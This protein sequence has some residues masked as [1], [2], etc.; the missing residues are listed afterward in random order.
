[1]ASFRLGSHGEEVRRIQERLAALG[2]YL[3][4]IDGA[5]GGGTEQAVRR[6]QQAERLGVDGVVGEETWEALFDETAPPPA[7]ASQ[8]VAYRCLALTG[9]FE[10]GAGFPDCFAGVSGDFDGQGLSMG[11]CQWNLGQRTLQPL[12]KAMFDRH[13]DV[14]TDVFGE[15]TPVL[16]AALEDSLEEQLALARA[17]QDPVRHFV[18]EPWRGM[19]RALGRT[20]AFQE[21]QLDAAAGLF[22]SAAQLCRDHDVRS[23]RALALMFDIVVQNGAA[24]GPV[25]K[26]RIMADFAALPEDLSAE[27]REVARLRVVANRRAESASARWVED[28]RARKLCIANGAGTV[29]GIHYDLEDQFALT[30]A[31]AVARTAPRA[32]G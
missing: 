13:A 12:F 28:V 31:P 15:N 2:L 1:M 20:P 7:L 19:F 26:A 17:I 24:F 29:H 10:T 5:F 8:P 14:M 21:V 25:L 11:V 23:E 16:V 9:A 3:G 30:L 32:A 18:H 22:A 4:P 27:E 6:F